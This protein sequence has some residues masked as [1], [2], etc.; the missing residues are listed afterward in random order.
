MPKIFCLSN[1]VGGGDGMAYAMAE[2]GTVLGSHWCSGEAFVSMDLG[3]KPGFRLDRHKD[4][5]AH[6][7]NG[8]NMEFVPASEVLTHPG[9]VKACELNRVAGT[10]NATIKARAG[11]V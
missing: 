6:Y 1:I 7:P 3:V 4:Y 10:L 5:A 9:L 2:D 11:V 8:Y